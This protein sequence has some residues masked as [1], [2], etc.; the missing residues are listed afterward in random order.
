MDII[1][2][3]TTISTTATSLFGLLNEQKIVVGDPKYVVILNGFATPLDLDIQQGDEVSIIERGVLPEQSQLEALMA[4]RHTPGVHKKLKAASVGIAGLGGLGSTIA[5][6]LARIG[7]GKLHLVDF[8]VVEPSNLNRQQYKI[9]HL[10]MKKTE[11]LKQEIS[12]INPFINVVVDDV[13]VTAENA[14]DLFAADQIICEAFDN[15]VAKAMLAN[16]VLTKLPDKPYV[17]ASGLAGYESANLIT[18][19]KLGANFYLA[20]DKVTGAQVGR[21]LMAPRVLVAAGHEANMILR[22][23]VG[24]DEV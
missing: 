14:V 23:I 24:E 22:L 7:V 3:S 15:P 6:A 20:G 8:D 18:T 16:E 21:G 13:K 5:I 10:G 4:S 17:G 19:Q 12:E 9:A 1:L 11:A 2:N